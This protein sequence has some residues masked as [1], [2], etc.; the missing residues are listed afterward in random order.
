MHDLDHPNTVKT[1]HEN[2]IHGT[3]NPDEAIHTDPFV[4][5]QKGVVSSLI[6]SES[7]WHANERVVSIN[8]D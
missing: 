5:E 8:I 1:N 7:T 2:N 6:Q 3:D 4:D